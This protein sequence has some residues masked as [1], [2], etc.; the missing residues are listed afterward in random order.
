[1]N[2]RADIPDIYYEGRECRQHGGGKL[3]C[4]VSPISVDGAWWLAGWHDSD[5]ELSH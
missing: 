3:A 1:M 4:P 2:K 5:M